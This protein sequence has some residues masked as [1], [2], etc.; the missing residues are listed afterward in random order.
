[1]I[2]SIELT[3]FQTHEKLLIQFSDTVSCVVGRSDLGKSSI[4]RALRWVTLNKPNGN[5]FITWD[6]TFSKVK[7]KIDGRKIIRKKGKSNSYLLDSKKYFAFGQSVPEE[8]RDFLNISEEINFQLQHSPPFWLMKSP[9]EVS[10]ELNQII[11]L[12]LIDKTLGNLASESRR[13]KAQVIFLEDRVNL[14]KEKK[15]SLSWVL[16]CNQEYQEIEALQDTLSESKSRI[17]CLQSAIKSV[18]S[19]D[20][21]SSRASEAILAGRKLLSFADNTFALTE[22]VEDLRNLINNLKELQGKECQ[23]KARMTTLSQDLET[24][25]EGRCPLCQSPFKKNSL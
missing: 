12:G 8:I 11:N 17:A 4:I 25:L 19:L 9:G 7:L 23:L 21:V 22:K 10:R 13:A 1:M 18:Q 5:T 16:E 15:K 6:K 20:E 3:N 14:A 24:K 2:E